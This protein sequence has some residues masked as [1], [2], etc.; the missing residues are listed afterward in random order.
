MAPL[1]RQAVQEMVDALIADHRWTLRLVQ[2]SVP[3]DARL[4]ICHHEP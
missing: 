1:T 4:A 3:N 2:V